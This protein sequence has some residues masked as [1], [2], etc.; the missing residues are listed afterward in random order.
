MRNKKKGPR[1]KTR[2]LHRRFEQERKKEV[3]SAAV[4]G[5]RKKRVAE[6]EWVTF[7]FFGLFAPKRKGRD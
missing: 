6:G 2:L 3:R 1:A 5:K 4:W 7:A